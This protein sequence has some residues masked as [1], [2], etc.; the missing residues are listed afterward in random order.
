MY[1][2]V[3]ELSHIKLIDICRSPLI[4]LPCFNCQVW[5]IDSYFSIG[6]LIINSFRLFIRAQ[7]NANFLVRKKSLSYSEMNS[8]IFKLYFVYNRHQ[9]NVSGLGVCT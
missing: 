1:D 8:L 5:I 3:R 7:K 4:I 2:L 9:V 6:Y